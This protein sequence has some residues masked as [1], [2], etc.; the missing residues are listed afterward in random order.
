MVGR[1]D[2]LFGRAHRGHRNA[3]PR[4]RRHPARSPRTAGRRCDV[5][6]QRAAHLRRRRRDR[7]PGPGG[8]LERAR[9]A[10]RLSHVRRLP[11]SP[12][13]ATFPS[14]STPSPRSR[15]SARPSRTSRRTKVPYET[16]LARYS[17]ISRGQI[18][19][20][21]SGMFKMIFHRDDAATAGLPLHRLRRDRADS[22]RPGRAGARRGPRLLSVDRLQLPDA[23]RVL[24][25]RRPQRRQQ[26][27]PRAERR[28]MRRATT[29]GKHQVAFQEFNQTSGRR[30][31]PGSCV[32]AVCINPPAD[33][34]RSTMCIKAPKLATRYA[35]L[36]TDT[37]GESIP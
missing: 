5:P 3:R 23:G 28:R 10:R 11:P 35:D 29:E 22:H 26:A 34:G 14:A 7:L 4:V 27:G 37:D 17:E 12:W 25:S 30:K 6:H 33:T 18:L 16:G 2:P 13:E 1:R 15:W 31:P 21:H 19:G 32:R 36:Y 24:Q 9:T 20:D 8:H